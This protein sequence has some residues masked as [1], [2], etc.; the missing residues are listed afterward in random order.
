LKSGL[1]CWL[2]TEH[3]SLIWYWYQFFL[4]L[5]VGWWSEYWISLFFRSWMY[6][7]IKLSN[8]CFVHSLWHYKRTKVITTKVTSWAFYVF[9]IEKCLTKYSPAC[10][11]TKG[12]IME[13]MKH[14]HLSK[15]TTSLFVTSHKNGPIIF[16]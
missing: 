2:F 15:K 7:Y 1:I 11:R 3:S 9:H 8:V 5:G 4:I 14:G 10:L 13:I 12:K 6:T 16:G